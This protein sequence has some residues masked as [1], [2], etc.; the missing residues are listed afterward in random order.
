LTKEQLRMRAI[1]SNGCERLPKGTNSPDRIMTNAIAERDWAHQAR[2]QAL[3][4]LAVAEEEE[5]LRISR[6]LHDH[7]GQM[8]T[9]LTLQAGRL[10]E[11]CRETELRSEAEALEATASHLGENIHD[12]TRELRPIASDAVALQT[13][14]THYVHRWSASVGLSVELRATVTTESG[15]TLQFKRTLYQIAKEVLTNI[16]KHARASKV[17]VTLERAGDELFLGIEDDGVGFEPRE[18][19]VVG[20]GLGLLG[21]HERADLIGATVQIESAPRQ[22]TV[23][24]VRVALP[25]PALDHP[26]R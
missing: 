26:S 20:R 4:R 3:H 25:P 19:R 18:T 7:F 1:A 11:A 5:L 16:A 24:T 21:I 13:A 22:G 23:V 14:L 15:L 8:L 12:F 10:K 6:D 9:L 2:L 17:T